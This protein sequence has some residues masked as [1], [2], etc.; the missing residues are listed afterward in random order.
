MSVICQICG[1]RGIVLKNEIAVP[2]SCVKQK[3][4]DKIYRDSRLPKK[5]LGCTLDNFNFKYYA[6]NCVDLEKG[7]TYYELARLAFQAAKNFIA[8]F[9]KD[10]NADGL[11][12]TGQVGSGKTFLACCIANALLKTRQGLLFA[13]VPD[14]LDQI[15]FTYDPGRGPDELTESG[16]LDTARRIP[17]LILDDLGAHNYTEWTRNRIYSIINYRLNHRLPVIVTTNIVLEDLEEYLGERTTSRL[18]EMCRPYRL[19]VDL[20][21][22]VIRRKERDLGNPAFPVGRSRS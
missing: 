2:C 19:L 18:L 11:L 21:I 15:R 17:L 13:V 22:R 12:F 20:D 1:D 9:Q 6:N 8:D 10:P 14:L 5:L 3:R 7:I 4:T 16:I